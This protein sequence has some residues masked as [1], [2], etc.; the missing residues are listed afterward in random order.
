MNPHQSRQT[1]SHHALL[2]PGSPPAVCPP[3]LPLHPHCHC[4]RLVR[5]QSVSG[6]QTLRGIEGQMLAPGRAKA[7]RPQQSRAPVPAPR[8]RSNHWS[9]SAA[10]VRSSAGHK[11]GCPGRAWRAPAANLQVA[12]MS[13]PKLGNRGTLMCLKKCA[14]GNGA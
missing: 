13:S 1:T 8:Q 12:V 10:G 9:R 2:A 4:C 7:G 5:R 3:C 11:T 6:L 14:P